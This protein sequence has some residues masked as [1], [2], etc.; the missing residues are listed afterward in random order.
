VELPE[1]PY[2]TVAGLVLDQLGCVPGG[3]EKVLVDG[4]WLEVV[5]VD[6]HAI[7]RLRLRPRTQP[8]GASNDRSNPS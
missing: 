6:H 1:G 7:Q 2:A 3:G 4:W 5:E 8:T